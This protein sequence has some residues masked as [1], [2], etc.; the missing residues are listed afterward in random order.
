MIPHMLPCYLSS[1]ENCPSTNK[2][3]DK[4]QYSVSFPILGMYYLLDLKYVEKCV[5]MGLE[6][7]T[8]QLIFSVQL[9]DIYTPFVVND[10]VLVNI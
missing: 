7:D 2:W 8:V 10:K 6:F 1:W 9:S 4:D 5:I 3:S